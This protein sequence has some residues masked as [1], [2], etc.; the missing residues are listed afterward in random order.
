MT[1]SELEA[2]SIK[3][4]EQLRAGCF[5]G[6]V[7]Y[8]QVTPILEGKHRRAGTRRAWVIEVSAPI[9]DGALLQRWG[10]SAKGRDSKPPALWVPQHLQLEIKA[11][12]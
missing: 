5:P 6:S 8:D 2:M 4:L 7:R 12:N 11:L 10:T 1:T 3:Q 9:S